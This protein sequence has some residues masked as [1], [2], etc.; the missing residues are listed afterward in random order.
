MRIGIVMFNFDEVIDRTQSDSMKWHK[1][2]GTDI[3]PLWVADTDFKSPPSIIEAIKK[4]ADE[5][6]FG[7]GGQE[8]ALAKAF[9]DWARTRYNWHVEKEWLIFLP[10]L[11]PALNTVLRSFTQANERSICPHPIYP[12]FMSAAKF[13]HREQAYAYLVEQDNRWVMDLGALEKSL[14]GNERL[15]MLCNPQNPGGTVYRKQELLAQLAFA[16]KYDLTVCSD[17][18]HCDLLLDDNIPHI[19]FASLNESAANRS[20]TLMA[21]SK[22]FNI[23]GLGASIAIIPNKQLRLQF[24]Q[25][26]AGIMPYLNI[27]S[28]S[29]AIAAYTDNSGWLAEQIGYLR[30]NRDYLYKEINQIKGLRLLPIEATYLAW[31]DASLLPIA[32]PHR[33]F[34]EAGVGLSAG[35]DY[36]NEKF[37]RLNFGCSRHLLEKAVQ[38]IKLACTAL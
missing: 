28:Y 27:L 16:E 37:V 14:Q 20:I 18:I 35:K 1:Y 25:A 5:G 11:V 33:F 22:T 8:E 15:L 29:A 34:E 26:T 36:G 12:P 38:R 3:I 10:G 32:N 23:A 30:G 7:Y 9:I 4:R 13:A 6:I 31:I 2:Q 19:P 17:E 24:T 21:P